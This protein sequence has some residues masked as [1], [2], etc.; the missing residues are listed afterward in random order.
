MQCKHPNCSNQLSKNKNY[1]SQNCHYDHRKIKP[2][3]QQEKRKKDEELIDY[4]KKLIDNDDIYKFISNNIFKF[5]NIPNLNEQEKILRMIN[6]FQL[7]IDNSFISSWKDLFDYLKGSK[8]CS[9]YYCS[10][11]SKFK[12]FSEGYYDFCSKECYNQWNSYNMKG[13]KNNFHK[14][15]PET[16]QRISKEKSIFLKNKIK[17]GEFNPKVTNSWANS[18]CNIYINGKNISLRSS[19]EAYFQLY[20]P[21]LYYEVLKI[22][23]IYKG[24]YHNYIIDFVDYENN[25]I[26]EIKPRS[27]SNNKINKIKRN[28]AK[29]WSNENNFK[30]YEISDDWFYKNYDE[31]ILINQPDEK[32]LKRLLSQFKNTKI[33]YES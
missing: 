25:I 7:K 6:K 24:N 20:Y 15:S 27:E 29:E 18:R 19:W 8:K 14:V 2:S 17:K 5:N 16:K 23:Y 32:R 12:R 9:N 13:D 22:P 11:E 30:F 3:K 26:Y 21:H 31:T 33:K 10:N 4:A 28:I 1:C